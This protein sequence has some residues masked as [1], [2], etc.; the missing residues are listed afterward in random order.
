MNLQMLMSAHATLALL[1]TNIILSVVAF[2]NPRLIEAMLFDI[3]RIRR[4]NEWHRTITSGFIHGDPMHLFMNMLSL[5]FIGP[6]LEG[7]LGTW[8]FLAFYM[9]CLVAG[10]AW[11]LMEHWRNMNYKALGASGAVSGVVAAFGLFAPFQLIIF[12]VVPMPAI[13]FALLF[14]AYSAFAS[15]GRVQDGIGHAAHLGG[16]LMGVVLVCVFW[17]AAIRYAWEEILIRLPF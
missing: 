5:F 14:I 12:F 13:L 8:T 17:P 9:A 2:S 15:G 4:N 3:G 6:W 10:S 7:G 1:A 11:T 16:A